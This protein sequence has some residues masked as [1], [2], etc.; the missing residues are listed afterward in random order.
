MKKIRMSDREKRKMI[1][2]KLHYRINEAITA[3]KIKSTE[4]IIAILLTEEDKAQF[5][6][7]A[8]TI[9]RCENPQDIKSYLDIPIRVSVC[10]ALMIK[11]KVP[12]LIEF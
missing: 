9:I 7:E 12:E 8:Q 5:D 4:P 1:N 3:H 2:L 11:H 10:S 6:D